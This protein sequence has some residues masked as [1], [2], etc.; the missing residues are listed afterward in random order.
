[1]GERSSNQY[2]GVTEIF[3]VSTVCDGNCDNT[4]VHSEKLTFTWGGCKTVRKTI[5]RSL[6]HELP[7]SSLKVPVALDYLSVQLLH[8]LGNL[9][10]IKKPLKTNLKTVSQYKIHCF[11]TDANICYTCFKDYLSYGK[12]RSQVLMNLLSF[13]QMEFLSYQPKD[14]PSFLAACCKKEKHE[15]VHHY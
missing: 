15:A 7:A 4:S 9:Q 3:R 8:F 5:V 14:N 10:I 13:D 6:P 2:S 1:M 12:Y 11:N